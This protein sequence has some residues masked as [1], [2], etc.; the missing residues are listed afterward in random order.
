MSRERRPS[1]RRVRRY[2]DPDDLITR[3]QTLPPATI[4]EPWVAETRLLLE[5]GDVL[6]CEPIAL[7][8]NYTFLLALGGRAEIASE[9]AQPDRDE[10]SHGGE[11]RLIAVYKPRRG[12]APLWDFPSG[13]LYRRE[14]AAYL[15]SQ[16]LGWPFIPPTVI[17]EGPYG[18]GAVQLYIKPSERADYLQF[19]PEHQADLARMHLFDHVVNNADR[20][21]SHVLRDEIGGIWG[22]DHGLTFHEEFKLRTVIFGFGGEPIPEELLSSLGALRHDK[23]R[24]ERLRGLLAEH[25]STRE[26][27]A[28]A[29]R[30]DSLLAKRQFP[31]LDPYENVPRGFF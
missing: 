2:I 11:S 10:V 14:Y 6:D 22:I 7:G 28:F 17:R 25:L 12:E 31:E 9:T 24:F 23:P 4:A 30:I 8:S 13:S 1:A 21:I 19:G 18:I 5:T 16:A 15:V 26:I 3:P 20:K 27:G 29:R